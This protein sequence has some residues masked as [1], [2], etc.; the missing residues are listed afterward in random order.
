M[1]FNKFVVDEDDRKMYEDKYEPDDDNFA[2]TIAKTV[3]TKMIA[4]TLISQ[5]TKTSSASGDF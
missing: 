4:T 1:E 5:L 3:L 2:D